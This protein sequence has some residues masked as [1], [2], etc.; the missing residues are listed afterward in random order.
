MLVMAFKS[1][2]SKR[3]GAGRVLLHGLQ[4][5]GCQE[6]RRRAVLGL[7]LEKVAG[8]ERAWRRGRGTAA[9]ATGFKEKE[10]VIW[11]RL[12]CKAVTPV[13]YNNKILSN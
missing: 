3:A 12:G 8:G 13:F 7:H 1:S 6:S 10:C 4:I 5:F 2:V 9:A 11:P